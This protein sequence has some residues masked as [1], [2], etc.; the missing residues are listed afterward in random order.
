MRTGTWRQQDDRG[1]DQRADDQD[2]EQRDGDAFP[3][4][5]RRVTP[6]Q[7]LENDSRQEKLG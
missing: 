1:D 3:V 4:P 2:D 7:L 5:L 6:Y